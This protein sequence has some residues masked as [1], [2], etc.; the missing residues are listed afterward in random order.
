MEKE[1]PPV[2]SDAEV[3]GKF[4]GRWIS[5]EMDRI[6]QRDDDVAFYESRFQFVLDTHDEHYKTVIQQAREETA[7]E[8]CEAYDAY[9]E[10]L[11]R[12]L[13]E[14]TQQ[15]I[16]HEKEHKAKIKSLKSKFLKET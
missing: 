11:G 16:K 5:R 2:L 9:I 12:G 10:S 6:A 14:I 1:K 7:M 13:S 4:G 3:T 15:V 8:L